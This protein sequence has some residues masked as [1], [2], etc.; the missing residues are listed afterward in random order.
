MQ[1]V[2]SGLLEA[3]Q[4]ELSFVDDCI[5]ITDCA[6]VVNRMEVGLPKGDA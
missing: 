3:E 6:M 5:A 4:T 2:V 1:R